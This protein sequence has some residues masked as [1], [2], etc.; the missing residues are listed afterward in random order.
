MAFLTLGVAVKCVII[1]VQQQISFGA[2]AEIA[3]KREDMMNSPDLASLLDLAHANSKWLQ[4]F[5]PLRS[6]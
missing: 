3:I 1:V 5:K 2:E 6:D 4:S